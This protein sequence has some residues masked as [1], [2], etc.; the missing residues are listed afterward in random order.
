MKN[1]K[2][3]SQYYDLLYQDKNYA[4]EIEY[5]HSLIGRYFSGNAIELLDLGSGTGKHGKLFAD[6]GY[7]VL[8]LERSAEMVAIANKNKHKNFN[9]I[10]SDITD[11]SLS[12]IF[13][14]V[15]ALFHVISYVNHNRDL[16]AVFDNVYAHLHQGG[17][18]IFDV[19]YSPAV[20][21]QKPETRIKRLKN[22]IMEITRIAEPELDHNAN[23]VT[24]NY[25]LFVK[26]LNNDQFQVIKE[27]H[28]MRHF[29]VPEISLFAQ[30]HGFEILKTEEF[31]TGKPPS[32]NTWGVCIIL[33]KQ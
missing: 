8:G 32:E 12:K 9:S 16:E 33:K 19:W 5:I 27:V 4:Q 23:V 11:F 15:T 21:T 7:N 10:Q 20:L 30:N 18:F 29:S 14:V 22:D 1:F 3:Y 25:H 31:L 13:D 28:P 6:G 26:E 2:L 24:V 17:I